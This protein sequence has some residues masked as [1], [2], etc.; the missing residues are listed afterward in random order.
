MN[1]AEPRSSRRSRASM[2]LEIRYERSFLR[3]LKQLEPQERQSIYQ[4]VFEDL[5]QLNQLSEL[6]DFRSMG[7]SGIFFRFTLGSCLISLEVTGQIVKLLR[8]LPKPQI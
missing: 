3:D 7:S 2:G 1:S 5:Y 6:P 8:L 4:F